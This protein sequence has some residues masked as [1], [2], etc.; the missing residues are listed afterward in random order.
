M[1]KRLLLGYHSNSGDSV[2]AL[3]KRKMALVFRNSELGR[4]RGNSPAAKP[5]FY[6]LYFWR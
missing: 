2:V 6:V 5:I 1:E 4:S 3:I